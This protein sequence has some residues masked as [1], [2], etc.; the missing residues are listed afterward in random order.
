[1][2]VC[3]WKVVYVVYENAASPVGSRVLIE[4]KRLNGDAVHTVKPD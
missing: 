3:W 2:L 1:M 4:D